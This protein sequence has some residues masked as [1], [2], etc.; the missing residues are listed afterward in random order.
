MAK[1]MRYSPSADG[2]PYETKMIDDLK[3]VIGHLR[4][5]ALR[6]HSQWT[7]LNSAEYLTMA[8]RLSEIKDELTYLIT[9]CV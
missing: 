8:S 7:D 4:G 1:P 3:H 6:N 2:Y 9:E 5:M